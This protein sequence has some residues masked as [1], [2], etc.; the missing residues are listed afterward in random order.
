M[1]L[2]GFIKKFTV[3]LAFLGLSTIAVAQAAQPSDMFMVRSTNKSVEGVVKAARAYTH[4]HHWIL[5][6]ANKIKRGKIVLMKVCIPSIGKKIFSHGLYLSAMLPC[7]NFG[8]YTQMGKTKVSMLKAKYMH[9]L[10][11]TPAMAKISM[12]VE[13]MLVDLMNAITK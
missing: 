2:L 8:V 12:E 5:L 3:L 1:R 13:P 7:G 6:D 9:L 4:K 10:V 11:P